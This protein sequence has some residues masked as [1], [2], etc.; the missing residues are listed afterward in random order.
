MADQILAQSSALNES[1]RLGLETSDQPRH[2]PIERVVP[3]K[4]SETSTSS[5]WAGISLLPGLWRGNEFWMWLAEPATE[6]RSSVAPGQAHTWAWTSALK[7]S[8][9]PRPATRSR[10]TSH[11]R[12]VTRAGSRA[13]GTAQ[14]MW[15]CWSRRSSTCRTPKI[16]GTHQDVLVPGGILIASSDQRTGPFPTPSGNVDSKPPNPFHVREWTTAE[17][18]QLLSGYFKVER[19]LGQG[20]YP[21]WKVVARRLIAKCHYL[22]WVRSGYSEPDQHGKSPRH[23]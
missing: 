12:S 17:F 7:P 8:R 19:V 18:T 16:H 3:G 14:L 10:K 9:S 5:T 21:Y 22:N 4:P 23:L 11:L 6:V 20:T 13:S 2:G 15:R 1:N